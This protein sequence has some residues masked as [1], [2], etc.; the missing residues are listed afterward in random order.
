MLSDLLYRLRALFR[1]KGMEAGLDEE[2][3]THVEH[4]VEKDVQSGLAREEAARRARLEFGGLDQVKEEC[5]DARGVNF[6]E[7]LIQDARYGL[8]M[9]VKTPGFTAVAVLTL[10]LGIGANTAIFSAVDAVL[11]KSL[12]YGDPDR[13]VYVSEFWPHEPLVRTAVPSPDFGNWREHSGLFDGMAGFGGGGAVNLTGS[14]EPER[15]QGVAVTANLFAVLGTEP[16]L[17]RSFLPR[18]DQPNGL[19]AVILS[20]ALWE[21]RFGRDPRLI[22]KAVM[23]DDKSYTVV[24]VMPASFRFP[25][26]GFRTE[27]FLPMGLPAGPNWHDPEHFRLL[28]MIGRLRPGV[29]IA[30]AKSELGGLARQTA[31]EEPPQFVRMR[32][33]MEIHVIPLHEQL[34]GDV[35]PVLLILLGAVGLVLLI[36]CV[37]VTH[38]QLAR[39]ALRQREIAVRAALGAGK[40]R[41][42]RQLLTE[43]VL[44]SLLGGG[45]GLAVAFYGVRLLRRL[46]PQTIP[47]LV[48]VRID[49]RMLGFALAVTLLTSIVFGLAP[50]LAATKTDVKE[51]LKEGGL[52]TTS[53]QV[54][55]RVRHV[56]VVAELALA[57]VLL[58]GSGL[59]IRSFIRLSAVDPGFEPR[60]LLTARIT[61]PKTKYAKPEQ[62]AAFLRHLLEGAQSLHGVQSAAIGSGLPL[63]GP[64][65]IMGIAVEGKPFPPPGAAPDIPY[66][67]V[68]A[69]YFRT[70]QMPLLR[71]RLFNQRDHEGAPLVA[72]VNQ[73]FVK[74]FFPDR[75]PIGKHVKTGAM[76]GP[77]CEI[78]GVVGDVKQ[79]GLN[80][81]NDPEIYAPYLQ[82]PE[83]EMILVLRSAA[84]PSGLTN[85]VRREVEGIDKNLPVYDAAT[86]EERLADSIAPAR[87]NTL[88]VSLFAAVALLLAAVGVYGVMSFAVARRTHEIG[89]RMALGADRRDV[90]RLVVGEAMILTAIGVGVGVAGALGLTRFLSGLLYGVRPTDPVTFSAV[91]TL[92]AA[93]ALLASYIPA[94]RAIRV[95]PVT[96]LRCE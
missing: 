40:L 57:I 85:T 3:H 81:E 69:D 17:G 79:Q 31:S 56:L 63:I 37:N 89:I 53:G 86:M 43:G 26:N 51:S 73:A 12:P 66:D 48:R 7:T 94:R 87:F 21:R 30:A 6:I 92:L 15:I 84:D 10:A 25:D 90:L 55:R 74:R 64:R 8:R 29:T 27:L 78:I 38:L 62:Q 19:G 93:V 22:G 4:Q 47:Q 42:A 36:G 70:L 95:E 58:A 5:R 91:A 71:G 52:R 76:T 96:A 2:L 88:L 61:L 28:R 34:V 46:G 45:G 16:S 83:P 59:L 33:D 23:L 11:L 44:L 67:D 14:G 65:S 49:A 20:H 41:L 39:S 18:E 9:L 77:W 80:R 72:V 35:R 32:A 50:V 68:S 60:H 13:L 82:S 75:D 54:H 24:G 1:R